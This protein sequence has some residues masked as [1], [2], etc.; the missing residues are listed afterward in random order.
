MAQM[1]G[2]RGLRCPPK[3]L[4][5]ADQMVLG[6]VDDD[7]DV[8]TAI[9]RLLRLLGHDVRLFASAEDFE[10]D[11]ILDC[12]ILDIRLPGLSGFEL[13]ERLRLSG[14]LLPIVFITGDP[15]WRDDV[16]LPDVPRLAK[17]FD[18]D[19]LI[20]AISEAV[21]ASRGTH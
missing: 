20:A 4:G 8:R 1:V 17:P 21:S 15:V 16:R 12:L 2:H 3:G 10:A 5:R 18:D 7:V 9:G 13:Y 14:C 6:V 11:P 19:R